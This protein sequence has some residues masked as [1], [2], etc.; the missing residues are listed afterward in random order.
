MCCKSGNEALQNRKKN[1]VGK[2]H[3]TLNEDKTDA[4]GK[5]LSTT[6]S[7]AEKIMMQNATFGK[8]P[9]VYTKSDQGDNADNQSNQDWCSLPCV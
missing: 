5:G 2:E 8:F 6:F 7:T 9:F 3:S 1:R 4:N